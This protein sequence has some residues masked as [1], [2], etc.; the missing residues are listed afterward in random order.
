MP[1]LAAASETVL[2]SDGACKI[3]GWPVA[4]QVAGSVL[5][6]QFDGPELGLTRHGDRMRSLDDQLRA[7]HQR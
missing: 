7:K 1:I 2:A 6:R 4:I 5:F 3:G